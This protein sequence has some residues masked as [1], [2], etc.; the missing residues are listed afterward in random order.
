LSRRRL[1]GPIAFAAL[2]ALAL[3]LRLSALDLAPLHQD[4]GL[5]G[6]LTLA[7]QRG[8]PFRYL[9]TDNHGPLFYHAGAL[10]FR[11]F[12]VC[13]TSLRLGP[14][15]A[16]ALLSLALLP[17]R[18]GIS[19]PGAFVAGLLV[20]IAPGFVYFSRAAIHE[21]Y[22]SLFTALWAVSLARFARRPTRRGAAACGGAAAGC[23]VTKETALLTAASLALGALAA[24]AAWWLAQPRGE[25]WARARAH[26]REAARVA[27][28]GVGVFAAVIVVFYTSFFTH[29]AGLRDFF[30]AF[31]EWI[32]YGTTGRNQAKPF[33]Y[34]WEL[35][36]ATQG[37]Y[38]WLWLPAAG[39][40]FWRRDPLGVGLAVWA[41]A[42]FGSYSALPYKTPWCVLQIELPMLWLLG[43]AVGHGIAAA[44]AARRPAARAAWLLACAAALLPAPAL[45]ARSLA[46]VRE[47]YDDPTLPYVYYHT[48]RSYFALLQD[49]FG[50][51]DAA[52]DADGRG[53]RMLN[54]DA[55]DPVRWYVEARG[56]APER[57]RYIET[58]PP[59]SARIVA[60]ETPEL[61]SAWIAEAQ[62]VI[63]SLR[64]LPDIRSVIA[65]SGEAWHEERYATRP[66]SETTLLIR[67]PLWDRYQAAGGRAASPWPRPCVGP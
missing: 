33:A 50:V 48:Q 2:F 37:A 5:N 65:A 47:R 43:W 23:F 61:P 26:L 35:M 22:L 58:P 32:S 7:V 4:E 66:D 28:L 49:L 63:S 38:R 34:Y 21:I 42:A 29:A 18:R 45:L 40:A 24:A 62:I 30:A 52:P 13:E 55:A 64:R 36:A 57:S 41:L 17:L 53:P 25:R 9:P 27:P 11:V 56:W 3:W 19:R 20:A 15:L 16:G 44:H 8:E 10:L 14:A 39:L 46:D 54:S 59:P 6:S 12:G 51:A 1:A 60:A 31:A 67:Q